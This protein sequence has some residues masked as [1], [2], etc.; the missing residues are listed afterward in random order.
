MDTDGYR[1]GKVS[2]NIII[3]PEEVTIIRIENKPTCKR[4]LL[5]GTFTEN[6]LGTTSL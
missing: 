4:K 5:N 6:T 2:K 3:Q 1:T